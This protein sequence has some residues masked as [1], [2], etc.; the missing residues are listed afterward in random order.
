MRI[1]VLR[2]RF[3]DNY[4]YGILCALRADVQ[5]FHEES[6]CRIIGVIPA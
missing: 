1:E 4:Q 2:E 3:A 5:C 6:M